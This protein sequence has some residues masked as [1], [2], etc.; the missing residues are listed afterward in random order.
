MKTI[1]KTFN[2]LFVKIGPNLASKILKSDTNFEVYTSKANTT[3]KEALQ[4][5]TNFWKDL[6]H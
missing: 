2:N 4:W 5:R 1:A 3:L 6:S